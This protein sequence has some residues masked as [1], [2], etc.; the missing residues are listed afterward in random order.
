MP[1]QQID[2]TLRVVT[3]HQRAQHV[4]FHDPVETEIGGPAPAPHAGRFARA[5]V[6]VLHPSATDEIRYSAP[7][8]FVIVNTT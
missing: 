8:S 1:G 3:V 4:G 6:V 2:A 5:H 7:W